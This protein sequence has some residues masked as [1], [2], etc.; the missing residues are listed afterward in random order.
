[1]ERA[2]IVFSKQSI[3]VL[4]LRQL[5]FRAYRKVTNS[6]QHCDNRPRGRV[7]F[8]MQSSGRERWLVHRR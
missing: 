5:C 7:L 1:M 6:L 4:F 2:V 3:R 8:S